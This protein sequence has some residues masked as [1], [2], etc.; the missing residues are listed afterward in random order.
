MSEG[1]IT[2]E[3]RGLIKTITDSH[4]PS[5]VRTKAVNDL[6]KTIHAHEKI[7]KALKEHFGE[8]DKI[9]QKTTGKEKQ[10]KIHD[11][12][13]ET[14][15]KLKQSGISDDYVAKSLIDEARNAG[16]H[17]FKSKVKKTDEEVAL[18]KTKVHG[19]K[20]QVTGLRKDAVKQKVE[21]FAKAHVEKQ[22]QAAALEKPAPTAR[23][24]VLGK[25]ATVHLPLQN[26]DVTITQVHT[27]PEVRKATEEIRRD[28]AHKFLMDLNNKLKN[29][30]AID[31]SFLKAVF[32]TARD[33]PLTEAGPYVIKQIIDLE[34]IEYFTTRKTS[35][36]QHKQ[37]ISDILGVIND[38]QDGLKNSKDIAAKLEELRGKT[39]GYN[40][41]MIHVGVIGGLFIAINALNMYAHSLIPERHYF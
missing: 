28:L 17:R 6:T 30:P 18:A 7:E 24:T 2:Q 4:A 35:D 13:E 20:K 27:S 11:L 22:E 19:W 21:T 36:A 32:A 3:F 40:W 31:Q 5:Q 26:R 29:N 9:K 37:I 14:V 12:T 38:N 33:L 25:A 23:E 1:G 16:L 41:D 8:S 15:A 39:R 34:N 10:S